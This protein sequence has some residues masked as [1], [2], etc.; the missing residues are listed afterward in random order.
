M[1][2]FILSAERKGDGF[3]GAIAGF[4]GVDMRLRPLSIA[5][6]STWSRLRTG[7]FV[8][9]PVLRTIQEDG[10]TTGASCSCPRPVNGLCFGSAFGACHSS[11]TPS[12]LSMALCS[13]LWIR[14]S[15]SRKE[16]GCISSPQH[17]GRPHGPFGR[18]ASSISWKCELSLH[19]KTSESQ[20]ERGVLGGES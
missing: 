9:V 20:S 2:L 14:Q 16:L 11:A 6:G 12:P 3:E 15:M 5:C 4:I 17:P 7:V 13:S 1:I 8:L 10:N 18:T 19:E